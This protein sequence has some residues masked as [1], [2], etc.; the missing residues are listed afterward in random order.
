M[1]RIMGID[2]GRRRCGVAVTDPLRIVATA[3]Q[4]VDTSRLPAFVSD[5]CAREQVDFIVAGLPR[6][7]HGNESESMRFIRPAI[8]RLRKALPAMEI[9]MWDERFTSAIAHRSM[10]DSGMSRT[11]RRDK[12]LAD[13]MAAVLILNSYLESRQYSGRE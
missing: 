5:Y 6:D 8:A 3:L 13:R 1:G 11:Q 2:F 9:V 4:T 12:S 7:L 10:I